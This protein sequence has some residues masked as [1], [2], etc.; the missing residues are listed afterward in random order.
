MASK[1]EVKGDG[2]HAIYKWLTSQAGDITVRWNFE[3]FMVNEKG[4]FVG[5]YRSQV[6]PMSQKIT[7]NL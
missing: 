2:Q 4:E 6:K 5:H 1:I 3:K 7:D